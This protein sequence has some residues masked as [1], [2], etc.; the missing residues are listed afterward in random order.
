[1]AAVRLLVLGIIIMQPKKG[2]KRKV[3]SFRPV[4][5]VVFEQDGQAQQFTQQVM[6]CGKLNDEQPNDDAFHAAKVQKVFDFGRVR[7]FECLTAN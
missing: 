2:R 4:R 5:I 1:M 6:T 7:G 3:G